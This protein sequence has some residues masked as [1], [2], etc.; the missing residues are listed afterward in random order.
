M[1]VAPLERAEPPLV[2][3]YSRFLSPLV[4]IEREK[5]EEEEREGRAVGVKQVAPAQ[6][7]ERRGISPTDT[8]VISLHLA[9]AFLL[10][11]R[12]LSLSSCPPCPGLSALLFFFLCHCRD[13]SAVFARLR[14]PSPFS[15]SPFFLR[16]RHVSCSPSLP[17]PPFPPS[18][19]L[20]IYSSSPRLIG[21][22]KK[23]TNPKKA[24]ISH[25]PAS[26][27]PFLIR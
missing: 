20:E 17:S 8:D 15:L 11:A 9:H 23:P 14:T 27:P 16:H 5:E 13:G 19:N 7:F 25:L 22:S 1:L 10:P 3:V 24:A 2:H 18:T 6:S 26:S 21:I 12:A 4:F